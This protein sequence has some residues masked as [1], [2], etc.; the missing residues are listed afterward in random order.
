MCLR[1]T[2]PPAD[3]AT[4]ARQFPLL[5]SDHLV[6]V[7]FRRTRRARS[8]RAGER[9]HGRYAS[10]SSAVDLDCRWVS[11]RR[12]RGC[13]GGEQEAVSTAGNRGDVFRSTRVILQLDAQI[14]DVAVHNVALRNVVG[15]PEIVQNLVAGQ[16]AAR[17]GSQ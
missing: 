1:H 15:A 10:T 11:E 12:T 13:G 14:A 8:R 3:R 2:R 4:G 5:K 16:Q 6:F 9:A 7:W 17:V